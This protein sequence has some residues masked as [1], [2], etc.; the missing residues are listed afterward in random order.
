MPILRNSAL[1]PAAVLCVCFAIPALAQSAADSKI[2]SGISS[3]DDES[4]YHN[5]VMANQRM[6]E[7]LKAKRYHYQFVFCR[8]AGHVD[9]RAVRQTLPA[10]LEYVWKGYP[11][12]R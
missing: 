6:A 5:W 9:G 11:I 2:Y 3:K 4:T 7:V 10:A 1:V 8:Q 12:G